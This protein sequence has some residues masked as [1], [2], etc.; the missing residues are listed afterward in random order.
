MPYGDIVFYISTGIL[1]VAFFLQS[2]KREK[3]RKLLKFVFWKS[4]GLALIYLSYITYLQYEAFQNGPIGITLGTVDGLKWFTG[5]MRLH[6]WNTYIISF[7]AALAIF[8]FA[9]FINKRKKEIFFENEEIYVGALGIFLVGYPAF[10]F[11]I[12]L[13]LLAAIITSLITKKQKERLSL[14]FF[15]M[16]TALI[17]L[18][19]V[20]FWAER[21]TWWATFK[22]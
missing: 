5:Y 16:P 4:T 11:Y 21:Q 10:F 6:F 18:S 15:W 7:I 22:F 2:S 3:T 1:L 8:A 12:P 17:I 9:K 20:Y 14:Y 13:V 19:I